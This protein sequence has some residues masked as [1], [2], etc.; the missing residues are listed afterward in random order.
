M[1]SQLK[2]ILCGALMTPFYAQ[3]QKPEKSTLSDTGDK[4][5]V[6]KAASGGMA[7]VKLGKL[8]MEKGT[9]PEVKAFGKRMVDD[10]SK[11][12]DEL[13]ALATRKNLMLPTDLGPEHKMTYEKL[14]KLNGKDFD[15][16]YIEAMVKDHDEDVQDFKK[17]SQAGMDPDLKAWA[18]K[19]LPVLEQHDHMA[20]QDK[21]ALK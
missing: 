2:W 11:A 17:Q 3:A 18:A 7:E 9:T 5:F 16:A 21:G 1:A 12:N 10:H 14:T 13:K 4:K 15:K 6:E 20:H 19:T 8:A